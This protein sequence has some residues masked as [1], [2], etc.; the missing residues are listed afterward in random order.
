MF[1]RQFASTMQPDDKKILYRLLAQEPVGALAV[2][3]EGQPVTGL[4]PFAATPDFSV[5]L[6]LASSLSRHT[7]ALTPGA[8]CSLL[9]QDTL[10]ER[11]DPHQVP[12]V[13]LEGTVRLVS[14]AD[15]DYDRARQIYLGKFPDSGK[16]FSFQDFNLYELAIIGGRLVTGFARAYNLSPQSLLSLTAA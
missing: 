2:V 11:P 15:A 1:D 13:S 5:V 16:L 7:A 14:R 9:I 12:R 3:V 8:P 10:G 4:L 6:I